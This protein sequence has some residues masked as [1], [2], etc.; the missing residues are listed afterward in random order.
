MGELILAI[1]PGA[2]STKIAIFEGKVE[3]FRSSLDHGAEELGRFERVADQMEY[4]LGLVLAA[5]KEAGTPLESLDAV[6]GRGGLLRPMAGGTYLVGEEMLADMR[7][8]S[9]GE[10]ASNLGPLLAWEIA[11]RAGVQAYTVDPVSVDELREEA[12]VSGLPE[13]PR[14]SYSHALNSKAVARLAAASLGKRYD[15]ARLVVA[16]LGTGI[17]VSAH[18]G[19]RMVDVNDSKE[20]GPFGPDRCGTLPAFRLVR[21]CY[22]GRYAEQELLKLLM[23]SG[24]LKALVGTKDLRAVEARAASGDEAADL[25]L[26]AMAYQVAK[27]IGAMSAVLGGGLD[28]IAITGGMARSERLVDEIRKRVRFIAPILLFPGEEEMTALALGALRVL[29]GED[30]AKRYGEASA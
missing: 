26:R 27:E 29:R 25:A 1:N 12:R 8:A 19:G 4:R 21:L 5:L 2:T 28:C 10:H 18:E 13:L 7:A 16:H 9:R 30:E 3:K 23:G 11:R 15:E 17:S 14:M 6:V 20:E 24:G 22:S